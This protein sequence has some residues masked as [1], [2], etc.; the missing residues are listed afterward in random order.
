MKSNRNKLFSLVLSL[1]LIF[2]ATVYP[3]Q[4]ADAATLISSGTW[5]TYYVSGGGSGGH[6]DSVKLTAWG[7]NYVASCTY[8]F[9][10]CTSIVA[11]ITAFEEGTFKTPV[12]MSG[13]VQFSRLTSSTFDID[14]DSSINYVYFRVYMSYSG[15]STAYTNGT[16]KLEGY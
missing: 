14:P 15:G 12:D 9:G 11:K 16:I 8:I 1:A 3:T 2:S 13:T 4:D 5:A 6:I 10:S 7:G